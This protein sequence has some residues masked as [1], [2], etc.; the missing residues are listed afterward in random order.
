[1][2]A[3]TTPQGHSPAFITPT[4]IYQS[5][6]HVVRVDVL[7]E[8]SLYV[9]FLD[10][11]EGKLIFKPSFFTGVFAHLSNIEEFQTVDIVNGAITWPGELDL[12][13]DAMHHE[14]QKNGQWVLS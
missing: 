5:P 10:G 2:R 6:W 8:F 4:I 11:V 7:P 12:A 9:Q 13:P 14:L 3:E 1:M